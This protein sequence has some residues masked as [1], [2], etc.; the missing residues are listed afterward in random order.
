MSVYYAV[1]TSS[2]P[3]VIAFP[4]YL[5]QFTR[6]KNPYSCI[7]GY[8]RPAPS[9]MQLLLSVLLNQHYRSHLSRICTWSYLS[10]PKNSSVHDALTFYLLGN[11]WFLCLELYVHNN[12]DILSHQPVESTPLLSALPS[13]T[14]TVATSSSS[15]VT[16][17]TSNVSAASRS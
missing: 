16:S 2:G 4:C 10:E 7:L 5:C 6:S 11:L 14:A 17:S 9:S 15:T 13:T 8:G 3:F 1:H 12:P